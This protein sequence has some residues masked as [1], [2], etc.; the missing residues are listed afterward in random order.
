MTN[1]VFLSIA[2]LVGIGAATQSAL[3]AAMGQ[4]KGPYEGTWI[5]ML[6]AIGGLAILFVV[7]GVTGRVPLLPAPFNHSVVFALVVILTGV[8]LAISVRGLNPAYAITGLFAIAYLLGIGYGAP[9]IGVALFIAGVT[10]GQLAGALAYD[11]VGAFGLTEHP[12][13]FT[14]IAG[15]GVVLTGALI[16]RFA[17]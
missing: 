6:A 17:P 1:T 4:N 11:H 14:R 9:K 3:L 16:V 10:V 7:R 8:A 15:L 2:V 12:A 5:N 13:S